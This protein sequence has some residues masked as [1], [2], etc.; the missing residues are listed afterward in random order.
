MLSHPL[1]VCLRDSLR[2]DPP[3]ICCAR[4]CSIALGNRIWFLRSEF[5]RIPIIPFID[6]KP[7][8][9]SSKHA[10]PRGGFTLVELL[11]VIAIIG[12]LV[13]LLLPAVQAARAAARRTQCKNNCK[14]IGLALHNY[15][16]SFRQFPAGWIS[17]QGEF[18]PG[19]GWAAAILPFAEQNNVYEQIDFRLPIE[20]SVHDAVRETVL[21]MYICPSDIA[22]DQ[23]LIAEGSGGHVHS[24][25]AS[26]VAPTSYAMSSAIVE[27]VDH[28]GPHLFTVSKS[29]YVGV[30]GSFEIHDN[31]YRG[32]GAFFADSRLRFRDFVD[33][34]SSTMMV[35]E[36][37]G[38]LGSA[39]WHGVIPEAAEPE[40]RVVG[41]TDHSPNSEHMHFED[42]SSEHVTGAHFTLADGSVRM[43]SDTI[44]LDVYRALSTRQ[45]GEPIQN[46][47]F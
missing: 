43:I 13:A 25:S 36:R 16:D 10:R 4:R 20:D 30:F 47:S 28:D 2:L 37:F 11:V 31:P 38:R 15:H 27:S 3:K 46:A 35:G 21:S 1:E 22:P 5:I 44:D 33:G 23:F 40:A 29:N 34:T 7:L 41:V 18:E 45:G 42:F 14:Q 9:L 17:Y 6:K 39:I 19:W 12:I 26:V 32:D 8:M 24:H